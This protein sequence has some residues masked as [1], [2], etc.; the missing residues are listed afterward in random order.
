MAAARHHHPAG[1]FTDA[2]LRSDIESDIA[3]ARGAERAGAS[4]M[5]SAADRYLDEL[6]ALDDGI[7]RPEY[8]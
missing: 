1:T 6:A 5:K 8:A 2:Q 7:W 4:S 3:A